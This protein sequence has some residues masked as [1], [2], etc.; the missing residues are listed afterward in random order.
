MDDKVSLPEIGLALESHFLTSRSEHYAGGRLQFAA[1]RPR[2]GVKCRKTFSSFRSRLAR[3]ISLSLVAVN[4]STWPGRKGETMVKE[5]LQEAGV[6]SRDAWS[7][8]L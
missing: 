7:P 3:L 8:G 2:A 6:E 5:Y 4:D 1:Q